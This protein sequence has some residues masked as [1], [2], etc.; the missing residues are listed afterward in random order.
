MFFLCP[1][2]ICYIQ[3]FIVRC[4]VFVVSNKI[5]GL[6]V[7]VQ[8]DGEWMWLM[9]GEKMQR[10]HL[11]WCINRCNWCGMY[12]VCGCCSEYTGFHEQQG[13]WKWESCQQ[14]CFA[15]S[16]Y[17]WGSRGFVQR[18]FHVLHVPQYVNLLLLYVVQY[19]WLYW[20]AYYF[21][22]GFWETPIGMPDS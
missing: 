10:A 13:Q 6:C 3:E 14:M 12:I 4:T 17:I 16:P 1:L 5:Q 8:F 2:Y 20:G 7:T 15:F 18:I 22:T 11:Q 19:F 9:M 21:M